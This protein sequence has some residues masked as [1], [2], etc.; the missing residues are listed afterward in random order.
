[1]N[2][3]ILSI[4]TELLLGEILDGNAA[5]LAS[6]LADI[7]VNVYWISQVGDNPERLREVFRRALDRSQL[8]LS[9]GGLGPTDDDQTRE[10]IAAVLREEPRVDPELEQELRRRFQRMGREMPERNLKQ[11]W[12]IP[13]AES[14]PN[15]LGTAPGWWVTAPGDRFIA[16]MPGVPTEMRSMWTDQVRGRVE[17]RSQ[18]SFLSETLRTF[19]A[20]ESAIEQQLGDLVKSAN[21]SVAT[22]AKQDGVYV[23]VAASA[24]SRE[25]A[26]Q[27]LQPVLDDVRSRLGDNVFSSNNDSLASVVGALLRDR[28][29]SVATAESITGGLVCSYLTDVPG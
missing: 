28:N 17:E 8:V 11:A 18:S 15:P 19:G 21:P 12:L 26:K 14:L 25:E 3:E 7:G 6:E 4:G 2:A 9:T 23:R 16:C 24:G 27:L 20:G 13:S 22:Y 10:A 5:Y 1:M 29:A